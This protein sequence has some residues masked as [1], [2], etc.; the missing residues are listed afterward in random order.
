VVCPSDKGI[1]RQTLVK[2]DIGPKVTST[3]TTKLGYPKSV[4]QAGKL[5]ARH[6]GRIKAR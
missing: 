2:T 1:E 6:K 5:N 4:E 3:V